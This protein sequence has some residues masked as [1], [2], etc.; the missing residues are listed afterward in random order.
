MW[1]GVWER[2]VWEIF[3]THTEIQT[4]TNPPTQFRSDLTIVANINT[5]IHY[6]AWEFIDTTGCIQIIKNP[7]FS[8]T[9]NRSPTRWRPKK[10]NQKG[11]GALIKYLYILNTYNVSM[12][13]LIMAELCILSWLTWNISRVQLD[14]TH[15]QLQDEQIYQ[16]LLNVERGLSL[17][18]SQINY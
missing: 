1:A 18:T 11:R 4:C 7:F 15:M 17:V 13:L 14:I 9:T 16:T 6:I 12:W 10:S 2:E 5:N 3:L 8:L